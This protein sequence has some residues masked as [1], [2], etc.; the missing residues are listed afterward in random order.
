[1]NQLTGLPYLN[2]DFLTNGLA[3]AMKDRNISSSLTH[4]EIAEAMLPGM[5]RKIILHGNSYMIEGGSLDLEAAAEIRNRHPR[6]MFIMVCLGFPSVSPEEKLH[7]IMSDP[8]TENNWLRKRSLDF[9]TA[10]I[11]KQIE[12]SR[13]YEAQ[14]EELG[15]EFCDT[16]QD[17]ETTV[18]GLAQTIARKVRPS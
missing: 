11:A 5:I 13:I 16:S 1:V 17:I 6:N 14:C 7:A 10:H 3:A 4:W 9:V 2:L 8:R 15:I 12:L 18:E